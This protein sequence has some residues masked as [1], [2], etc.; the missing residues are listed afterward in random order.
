M[1]K[2]ELYQRI[3]VP[4]YAVLVAPDGTINLNRA[5]GVLVLDGELLPDLNLAE[6]VIAS[7]RDRRP[8]QVMT[9]ENCRCARCRSQREP[10][11]KSFRVDEG[12]LMTREEFIQAVESGAFIDY[13][14][15]CHLVSGESLSPLGA[16]EVSDVSLSPSEVEDFVWPEW[17]THVL[18]Y[19]R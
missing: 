14:G 13:D 10:K 16:G 6:S 5:E 12:D 8:L 1:T 3:L 17:A 2:A 4:H 18:W 11:F 7:W 19:N 15:Y 9:C